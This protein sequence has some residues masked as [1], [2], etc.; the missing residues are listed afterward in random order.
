MVSPTFDL[1]HCE[2]WAKTNRGRGQCVPLTDQ[3]T[4][5]DDRVK[6]GHFK[7]LSTFKCPHDATTALS[8]ITKISRGTKCNFAVNSLCSSLSKIRILHH[9]LT[10]DPIVVIPTINLVCHQTLVISC[11][12][13]PN[14][15]INP[16]QS[17]DRTTND[18][19]LFPANFWFCPPLPIL[20]YSLT[21]IVTHMP[22]R[23]C[24]RKNGRTHSTAFQSPPKKHPPTHQNRRRRGDRLGIRSTIPQL[25]SN[26]FK[27][28][29]LC[30]WTTFKLIS[31]TIGWTA[32]LERMDRRCIKVLLWWIV[33][34]SGTKC[35]LN[36]PDCRKCCA[37]AA[38]AAAARN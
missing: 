13:L 21:E 1:T 12:L 33:V 11:C 9:F 17:S 24:R 20:R 10:S 25:N 6:V 3:K 22:G 31:R 28:Y 38:A 8:S 35:S 15:T 19:A 32:S 37:I 18:A 2:N 23:T 30:T 5:V 16:S 14:P 7:E 36:N 27:W 29:L 34:L 26:L 4:S